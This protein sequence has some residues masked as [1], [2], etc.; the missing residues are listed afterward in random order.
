[1]LLTRKSCYL[2]KDNDELEASRLDERDCY[3]GLPSCWCLSAKDLQHMTWLLTL[4]DDLYISPIAADRKPQLVL[5]VRTGTGSWAVEFAKQNLSF[6]GIGNHLL[7]MQPF[8]TPFNCE[9][10]IENV[11]ADWTF[12]EPFD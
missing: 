4:D 3:H 5:E 7:V 10:K 6:R 9:F 11:G 2:P 8:T 1:M 12:S